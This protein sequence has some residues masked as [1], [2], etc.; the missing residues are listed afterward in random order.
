VFRDHLAAE[1][2]AV[3]GELGGAQQANAR[4]AAELL[5]ALVESPEFAEF[6]TPAAYALLP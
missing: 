4:A 3:L 6:F 5:R 1:L 2:T